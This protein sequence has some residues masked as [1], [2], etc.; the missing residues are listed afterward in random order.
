[1]SKIFEMR[2]VGMFFV[3]LFVAGI[4]LSSCRAQKQACAAYS[5]AEPVKEDQSNS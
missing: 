4:A 3:L 5:Y 2:K 1:M